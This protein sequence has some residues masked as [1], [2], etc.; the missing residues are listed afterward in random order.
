VWLNLLKQAPLH[1]MITGGVTAL[2]FF[3]LPPLAA[4][5]Q[6]LKATDFARGVA[7]QYN[8]RLNE[9]LRNPAPDPVPSRKGSVGSYLEHF[10]AHIV[11]EKAAP[12]FYEARIKYYQGKSKAAFN[13]AADPAPEQPEQKPEQKKPPK[14]PAPG[15]QPG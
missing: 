4:T 3:G 5:R 15:A 1:M 14:P 10:I 12:E 8:T 11:V 7:Y 9:L 13:K 2:K 6:S